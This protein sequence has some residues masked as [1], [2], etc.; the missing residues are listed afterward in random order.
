MRVC[1]LAYLLF[2]SLKLWLHI[3]VEFRNKIV[4]PSN[5]LWLK[6]HRPTSVG[7]EGPY[8]IGRGENK[9]ICWMSSGR[10]NLVRYPSVLGSLFKKQQ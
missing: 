7:T 6:W 1:M 3:P 10:C 8:I 2:L 9:V 4:R 5:N